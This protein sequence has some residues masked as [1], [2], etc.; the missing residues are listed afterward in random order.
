MPGKDKIRRTTRVWAGEVPAASNKHDQLAMTPVPGVF[1]AA[2]PSLGKVR[3]PLRWCQRVVY[4][5]DQPVGTALS[6]V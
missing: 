2:A 5:R 6:G 4:M 1:V 3:Q